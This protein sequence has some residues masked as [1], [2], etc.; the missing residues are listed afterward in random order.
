VRLLVERITLHKSEIGKT[1]VA[2][3]YR[4]GP[5]ESAEPALPEYYG[6]LEQADDFVGVEQNSGPRDAEKM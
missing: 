5:P 1:T 4:F 2:I 6:E 3:T